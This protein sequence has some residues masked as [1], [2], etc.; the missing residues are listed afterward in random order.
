MDRLRRIQS[1]LAGVWDEAAKPTV[2]STGNSKVS[3]TVYMLFGT[4]LS[5]PAIGTKE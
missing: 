1:L 3:N 5:G 4:G 2:P